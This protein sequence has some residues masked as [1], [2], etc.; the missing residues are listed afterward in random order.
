MMGIFLLSALYAVLGSFLMLRCNIKGFR[1]EAFA[2]FCLKHSKREQLSL[3]RSEH[4]GAQPALFEKAC[5]RLTLDT[6]YGSGSCHRY[7]RLSLCDR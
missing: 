4:S 2:K 3:L 1:P 7:D 6:T 5:W